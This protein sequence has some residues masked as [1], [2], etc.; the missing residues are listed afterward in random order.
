MLNIFHPHNAPYFNQGC[1][2]YVLAMI[3]IAA[4]Y[5]RFH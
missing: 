2:L 1:L 5:F 3:L 4:L